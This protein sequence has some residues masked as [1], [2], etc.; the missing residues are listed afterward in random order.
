[1]KR[2]TGKKGSRERL[3]KSVITGR[4][5]G[6]LGGVL[7]LFNIV[8]VVKHDTCLYDEMED[9]IGEERQNGNMG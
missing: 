7:S 5:T 6:V 8:E 3:G 2:R 1:M 4:Q 9:G